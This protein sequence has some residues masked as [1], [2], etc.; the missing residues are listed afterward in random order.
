MLA[1]VYE[2]TTTHSRELRKKNMQR[3]LYY[4]EVEELCLPHVGK[5]GRNSDVALFPQS[6]VQ[7]APVTDSEL[8]WL[9]YS[10]IHLQ[11]FHY[12]GI[13]QKMNEKHLV[14]LALRH[15]TFVK[16]CFLI[17]NFFALKNKCSGVTYLIHI[18]K[19]RNLLLE[20]AEQLPFEKG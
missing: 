17:T 15:A 13:S 4:T 2:P 16:L 8:Y 10:S 11:V 5:H 14:P 7:N 6:Q 18:S 3:Y 1:A 20:L 9:Q 19:Q 12:G